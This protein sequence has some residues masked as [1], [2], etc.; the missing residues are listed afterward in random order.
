MDN[1]ASWSGTILNVIGA[2]AIGA[3][4]IDK[5]D[6]GLDWFRALPIHWALVLFLGYINEFLVPNLVKWVASKIPSTP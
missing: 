6:V 4:F 5:I 1:K 2:L 3:V